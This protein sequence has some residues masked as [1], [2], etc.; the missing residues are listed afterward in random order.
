V[1]LLNTTHPAISPNFT[2]GDY[3]NLVI[4]GAQPNQ[5]VQIGGSANGNQLP[6]SNLG[7]TNSQG[8]LTAT[9]QETA[10]DVGTYVETLY[11]AGTPLSYNFFVV[12]GPVIALKNTTHPAL[13]PDFIEGDSFQLDIIGPPNEGVTIGGTFNGTQLPVSSLGATDSNG[14]LAVT[15]TLQ[16]SDVGN[17][18]ETVSVNGVNA[19]PNPLSFIVAAQTGGPSGGC[20][21][22]FSPSPLV[23]DSIDYYSGG[24]YQHSYFASGT[25]QAKSSFPVCAPV[26]YATGGTSE[27]LGLSGVSGPTITESQSGPNWSTGFTYTDFGNGKPLPPYY[28]YVEAWG[29]EVEGINVL[30]GQAF[31]GTT[32]VT[33]YILQVD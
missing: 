28:P 25:T 9:G 26:A 17:W 31:S 29:L 30:N 4:T 7:T 24:V 22:S 14:N 5:V 19:T 12:N 18:T 6:I 15:G 23:L 20:T 16:A 3:F 27:Y 10:S 21:Q 1:Q 2:V 8:S 32:T 13:S 11:F 33:L